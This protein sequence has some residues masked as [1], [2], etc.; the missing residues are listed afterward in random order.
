[1]PIGASARIDDLATEAVLLARSQR[2]RSG[3]GPIGFE[4]LEATTGVL[5]MVK[6]AAEIS[7]IRVATELSAQGHLAAM[8]AA[9]AGAGEWEVQAALESTFRALGAAGPA[10]PSIVGTG[11]N[12]TVLHYVTN[13]SRM[14]DGD[15]LLIDA[16]A[17]WGMYVGDISRTFPVSGEFT[18]S[19]RDLYQVVLAAEEAA[20]AAATPG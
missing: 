9:R 11:V 19:Q 20:I 18:T 17:E 1:Y 4:D 15:L 8:R 6:D 5:R 3:R 14:R 10:F 7:R 13:E 12:A 2:Q 16:G